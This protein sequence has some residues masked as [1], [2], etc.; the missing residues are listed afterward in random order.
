MGESI[1][2][3]ESKLNQP[4]CLEHSAEAHSQEGNG[5]HEEVQSTRLPNPTKDQ[6]SGYGDPLQECQKKRAS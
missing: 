6:D 2:R 1:R 5:A 3:I 4:C